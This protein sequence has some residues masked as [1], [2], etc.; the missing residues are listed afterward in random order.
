MLAQLPLALPLFYDVIERHKLPPPEGCVPWAALPGWDRYWTSGKPPVGVGASCVQHGNGN[1]LE[2]CAHSRQFKDCVRNESG[3][4][5]P[6]FGLAY[7]VS[8]TTGNMTFCT[9]AMQVPEQINVQIASSSGVVVSFV[10]FEPVAPQQPPVAIVSRRGTVGHE[11]TLRG[12]THRHVTTGGRVYWMHFVLLADLAPR[13]RYDYRVSSGGAGAKLSDRFSFRAPYGEGETKVDLYGDMGV[14]T[15]NNMGNLYNDTVVREDADLIMHMGDHAYNEG[16]GDERRADAYLNAFQQ[17]IANVPWMPIVGNHEIYGTNLSRFLDSTFEKWGPIAGGVGEHWGDAQLEGESTATSA[18]GA[19]LSAGNH[20]S[21]GIHSTVPSHSSRYFSVEFGLL[22][23]ATVSLNGYNQADPCTERCNAAQLA[24]LRKDLAAVNRTRT[25][26]VI[27]ASHY[28]LYL[29]HNQ[30]C[31]SWCVKEPCVKGVNDA[32]PADELAWFASEKCEQTGHS[33]SCKPDGWPRNAS[34]SQRARGGGMTAACNDFEPLL[35]EFGVD[36]Y[37][38][39]HLHFYQRLDGPMRRGVVISNGTVNPRGPVHVTTG[40][41]GPPKGTSCEHFG[42]QG[43]PPAGV[44]AVCVGSLQFSYSRLVT[45]N[46]SH[47]E[48]LQIRN[49]DSAIVDRWTLQ[50]DRHGPFPWADD[51]RPVVAPNET[52]AVPIKTDDHVRAAAA[53]V[54]APVALLIATAELNSSWGLIRAAGSTVEL[55]ASHMTVASV[56]AECVLIEALP[57]GTIV[58]FRY[59]SLSGDGGGAVLRRWLSHD[60]LQS[61]EAG[62]VVLDA[63]QT[64]NGE[65]AMAKRPSG[66]AANSS[67]VGPAYL[68][69]VFHSG[70]YAFGYGSSDGVAFAPIAKAPAGETAAA[71]LTSRPD[72]VEGEAASCAAN[73]HCLFTDHDAIGSNNATF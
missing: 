60:S 3:W 64:S 39:G 54:S 58:L 8:R 71:K 42:Q 18:L 20:H 25:P 15:F 5:Q 28:P 40:S 27:V 37:L 67:E 36:L 47:L 2:P 14:F 69:M 45:S 32:T 19:F 23:I 41:G 6:A 55:E 34:N 35:F 38:A 48:W 13:Q 12:V 11:A 4:D 31:G 56:A 63:N 61:F 70:Q 44:Y 50:Q 33:A 62:N 65:L 29:A 26:W 7:C 49:N 57:N 53:N 73:P 21:A 72:V 46:A 22:H 1:P 66:A 17:T 24:W 43:H 16:D 51:A 59:G 30:P 9:S 10:T 68:V 52:R